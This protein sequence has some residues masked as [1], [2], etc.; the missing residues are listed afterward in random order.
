EWRYV[1]RNVLP[2]LPLYLAVSAFDYGAPAA[3]LPGLESNR[4]DAL[5]EAL[6][7]EPTSQEQPLDV[8]VYPNPYRVEGNYRALGFEGRGEERRTDE[9]VRAV[10]FTNLPP[11]CDIKIYSLDGDMIRQ[12]IHDKAPDDP[13][14]MH[15]SWDVISRNLQ[16][17]VSGIYYWVVTTPEGLS[18]IGKLVLIM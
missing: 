15:D 18:Q 12:I 17:P 1:F 9:R 10:H 5:V 16:V 14:A 13:S 11:V 3:G 6:A 4:L 2:S 7:Q 8:V